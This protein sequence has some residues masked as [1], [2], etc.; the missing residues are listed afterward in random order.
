MNQ[1]QVWLGQQWIQTAAQA[2]RKHGF[3]V[4]IVN[5]KQDAR[6]A[7]LEMIPPSASVG[8]PGTVTIRELGLLDA[9]ESRGNR[10]FHHWIPGLTSEQD[11]AVRISELTADVFLTSGNAITLDGHIVNIDGSGSRV[12]AMIFGPSHVILVAGANKVVR[13]VPAAISHIKNVVAPM[14]ARRLGAKTPC[15]SLGV[16]TDCDAPARICCVTTILERRPSKTPFDV[17]LIGEPA[18]F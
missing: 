7:V 8:V 18:G 4:T 11:T 16:C 6:S 14:N 17:I 15:A 3:N 5:T 2:L 1:F 10:V 13:D 12:A 9:L